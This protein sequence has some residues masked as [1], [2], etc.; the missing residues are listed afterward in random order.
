MKSKVM[1]Q[2]RLLHFQK[3]AHPTAS[4]YERQWHIPEGKKP[5]IPLSESCLQTFVPGLNDMDQEIRIL[6]TCMLDGPGPWKSWYLFALTEL[7]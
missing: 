3:T 2:A 7:V 1:R 5:G 6:L 4:A